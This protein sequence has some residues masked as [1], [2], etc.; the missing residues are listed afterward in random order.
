M[1]S[2]RKQQTAKTGQQMI[3]PAWF[4]T[5]KQYINTAY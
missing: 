4:L 2:Q 3:V 5:A 1:A